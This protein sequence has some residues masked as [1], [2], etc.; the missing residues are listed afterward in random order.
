MGPSIRLALRYLRSHKARLGAAILAQGLYE[1]VPMQVPV[2]TGMIIDGLTRKSISLYGMTWG[3]GEPIA[4]VQLAAIGLAAVAVI[5]AVS[6][7]ARTTAMAT[8]SRHFVTT[9]RMAVLER[10]MM[11]SIGS[12]QQYG[13]GDL[14]ERAVRDPD[15][16]RSFVE[17]VFVRTV[18]SAMR[19]IYPIVMLL[20]INRRLA[21]IAMAVLPI[22]WLGSMLVQTKLHAATQASRESR[23]HLTSTVKECLDGL[24]TVKALHAERQAAEKM[25]G[26]ADRVEEALLRP[27]HFSALLSGIVWLTTGIGVAL[28]WWQGALLVLGGEMSVGQLVVFAGF[29]AFVYRPFRQFTDIASTYRQ[30]AVS[31]ERIEDLLQT[32]STVLD[33]PAAGVLRVDQGCIEFHGVSF[34][35]GNQTILSNTILTIR[36]RQLTAIVG[37]SGAGKTSLLRLIARFYDPTRGQV[38]IDGQPIERVTLASLRSQ[39]VVVPQQTIMFSGTVLD[40]LLLARPEASMVQVEAACAAASALEFI[41]RLDHGFQTRLGSSGVGLS[42]GQMKRLAIARALLTNPRIL[43]LDEP[44]SSLDA[45]AT[46]AILRVLRRLS[47]KL[48]VVLVEHNPRIAGHAD[49]LVVIDAARVVA[50]GDHESLLVRSQTYRE[51]F[52]AEA[53]VERRTYGEQQRAI[54]Q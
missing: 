33:H 51:L 22:Q 37:R 12:Y 40:N 46:A 4:V 32:D 3:V 48:T 17:R 35:Y 26:R 6:A 39:V 8:L 10:L 18:T 27:S 53:K 11:L 2:L 34:S 13:V 41:R 16:A 52:G 36:P 44:V 50:E 1:L 25:Y 31:L 43:L 49:H 23:V 7:Y 38:L 14:L 47:Q 42:G 9:L 5:A 24:E 21:L 15:Q 20:L 54:L 29:S 30:G 19:A 45:E 28:I